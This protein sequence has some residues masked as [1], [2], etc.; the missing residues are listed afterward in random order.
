MVNTTCNSTDDIIKKLQ[1]LKGKTKLNFYTIVSKCYYNMN[2]RMVDDPFAN[3]A[4]GISE[5]Y[6]EVLLVMKFLQTKP[7][8]KVVIIK[9][10]DLYQTVIENR[11][12]K[13]IVDNQ[14]ENEYIN[15]NDFI[16]PNHKPR[17][18]ILWSRKQ[19][20]HIYQFK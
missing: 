7:Q 6:H 5:I 9:Y 19:R 12:K 1:S 13:E 20:S 8:V 17:E 4:Q 3:N 10:Y 11:D 18:T 16:L 15:F 2:I 14:Y